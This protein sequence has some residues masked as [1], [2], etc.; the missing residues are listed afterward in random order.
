MRKCKS[1]PR[2]RCAGSHFRHIL[3]IMGTRMEAE[4][5]VAETRAA[6]LH[7]FSGVGHG[8]GLRDTLKGEVAGWPSRFLEWLEVRKLMK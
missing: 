7:V 4:L 2:G 5:E 6:E 1:C 8:F 3:A